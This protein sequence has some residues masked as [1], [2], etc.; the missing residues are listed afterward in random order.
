MIGMKYDFDD[1]RP[2]SVS[3][4]QVKR[5]KC[6]KIIIR[7]FMQ[8]GKSCFCFILKGEYFSVRFLTNTDNN[9]KY[10]TLSPR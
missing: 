3:K 5:N 9:K 6:N 2:S 4:G 10:N 7:I 1:S 8:I